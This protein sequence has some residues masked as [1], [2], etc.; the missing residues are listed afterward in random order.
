M[1]NLQHNKGR[2]LHR[3]DIFTET[4]KRCGIMSRKVPYILDKYH[5]IGGV[6]FNREFSID[7]GKTWTKE[8]IDCKPKTKN[9]E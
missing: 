8:W 1:N 2:K 9:N 5:L 7:N 6:K 3:Y 4:C